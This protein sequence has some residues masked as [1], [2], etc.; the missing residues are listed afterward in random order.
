MWTAGG[1]QDTDYKVETD[2]LYKIA[3]QW[4]P[5]IQPR[6]VSSVLSDDLEGWE[7]GWWEGGAKWGDMCIH[8]TDSLHGAAET[9]TTL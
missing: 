6:E 2:A 8:T 7:G 9:N 1:G 4:E 5:A 3:I